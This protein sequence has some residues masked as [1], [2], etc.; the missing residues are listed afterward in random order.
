MLFRPSSNSFT[1]AKIVGL[2]ALVFLP[3]IFAS[4]FPLA[5]YP[6]VTIVVATG[7]ILLSRRA[8]ATP[9][10]GKDG[11]HAFSPGMRHGAAAP[12]DSEQSVEDCSLCTCRIQ[13]SICRCE[14]GRDLCR[15][16]GNPGGCNLLRP[17]FYEK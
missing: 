6:W 8:P 7:A 13:G 14:Y 10:D 2:V 5:L 12:E 11:K 4:S 15:R 1:A 17:C 9:I 16:F 3:V